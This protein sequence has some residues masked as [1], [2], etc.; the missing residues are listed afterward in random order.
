MLKQHL[1]TASPESLKVLASYLC[2]PALH[3]P[4]IPSGLHT[5]RL[6][7]T[8]SIKPQVKI[9]TCFLLPFVHVCGYMCICVHVYMCAGTHACVYKWRPK[10]NFKAFILFLSLNL[11][12]WPGAHPFSSTE[13][14]AS[15]PQGPM[16]LCLP[17][18]GI[19][20]VCHHAWVL[21]TELRSLH[22]HRSYFTD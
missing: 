6:I 13:S 12:H 21:G 7:S 14:L 19:T 15:E 3:T 11:A 18:T 1:N 8:S 10:V 22:L 20:S 5:S 2:L 9:S 17:S 4:P 16:Y